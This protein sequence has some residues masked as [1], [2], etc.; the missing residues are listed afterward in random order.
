MDLKKDITRAKRFLKENNV[1]VLSI[2][3]SLVLADIFMI[4]GSSDVRTYGLL[5]AYVVDSAVVKR[6]SKVTFLGCLA[7]LMLMYVA[8]LFTGTSVQTEKAAVWLFLLL[9][10][11][12]VQL[13]KE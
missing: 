4:P 6:T 1:T 9:V 11:G 7:L 12:V 8:Y 5:L 2:L 10:V 3:V 13:W